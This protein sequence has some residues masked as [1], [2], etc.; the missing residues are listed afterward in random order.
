MWLPSRWSV[1]ARQ[2]PGRTDNA[3]WRRFKSLRAIKNGTARPDLK[4]IRGPRGRF[5]RSADR[6]AGPEG[7]ASLDVPQSADASAKAGSDNTP[8]ERNSQDR[9]AA[10]ATSR[11]GTH[12]TST[13]QPSLSQSA[14]AAASHIVDSAAEA[15]ATGLNRF[16]AAAALRKGRRCLNAKRTAAKAGLDEHRCED[17]SSDGCKRGN[18][19]AQ[20]DQSVHKQKGLLGQSQEGE[21]GGSE[22]VGTE[23]KEVCRQLRPRSVH[24]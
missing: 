12:S 3:C 17:D 7:T 5:A 13:E 18:E 16:G 4:L 9:P 23:K 15:K 22:N 1:V 11:E 19:A 6:I 24:R 14:P 21:H 10:A 20:Q 2:L 8:C